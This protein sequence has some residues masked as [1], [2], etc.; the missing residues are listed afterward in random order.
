MT[1]CAFCSSE[2]EAH[3]PVRVEYDDA[4][5]RFCNWACLEQYIN[6]E[7]LTTGACCEWNPD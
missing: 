3:D 4:Q 2:V 1:D 5:L 6:R 7:E